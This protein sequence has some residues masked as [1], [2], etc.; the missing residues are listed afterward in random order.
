LAERLRIGIAGALGRMGRAVTA[1]VDA[2]DAAEVAGLFDLPEQTGAALDGRTLGSADAALAAAEV[3]VD[4]T[5]VAASSALAAK[6]AAR[7]APALVIGATGGT[8]EDDAAITTAAGRIAI[9]R[10]PSYSLGVNILMGLVEQA[11]ER[12]GPRDWDIEIFEAHHKR[13]VDAPSGTALRLGEA[14]ARGRGVDLGAV[15][16]RVRDGLPGA[17]REGAIGFSVLRGGGIVGEHSV[18]FIAEDESLTLSHS[19]RD[20]SLFA[21]GALAAALWVAGKPPGLYDMQDVL[22]FRRG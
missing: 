22:G 2:S 12:M 17:R 19:A 3:I 18:S 9:V 6:A 1:A 21:R 11:A 14:A 7:G 5:T 20:R 16:D 15:A 13:K 8:A 4:F 10:A